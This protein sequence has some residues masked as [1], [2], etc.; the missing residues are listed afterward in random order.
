[1]DIL[2][3]GKQ[4]F[5]KPQKSARYRKTFPLPIYKLGPYNGC[6]QFNRPVIPVLQQKV[7]AVNHASAAALRSATEV[8]T[9]I[10]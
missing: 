10:I 6:I 8:S 3:P 5:G 1:L 4:E 2:L 7:S 9:T